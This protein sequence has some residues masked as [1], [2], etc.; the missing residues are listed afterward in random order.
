MLTSSI[1]KLDRPYPIVYYKGR[2]LLQVGTL[3][4]VSD[5]LVGRFLD[6]SH[7]NQE[8][9]PILSYKARLFGNPPCDQILDET[10]SIC[11]KT[12]RLN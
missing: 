9:Y 3:L 10:M 12:M 6:L 2:L 11:M 8:A 5:K 4:V 7:F 1:I